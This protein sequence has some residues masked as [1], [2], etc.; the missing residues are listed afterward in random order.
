MVPVLLASTD[1]NAAYGLE[2]VGLALVVVLFW[3]K[4]R[5]LLSRAMSA[6]AER[7][8]ASLE[9][10]KEAQLEAEKIVE[11][12]RTALDSA[13]QEAEALVDQSRHGAERLLEEG[14]RR[15]E[16]EYARVVARAETE[17]ALERARIEG[18]IGAELSDL[19]L[20][21]A[22]EIVEAELDAEAQHRLFSEVIE[23]AEAEAG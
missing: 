11:R 3:T 7:I 18:E 2:W 12:A 22:S 13:R 1:W 9:S 5:P 23:A 19:V 15:A 10:G 16:E 21:F 6:Q 14:R 8:R 17:V 4:I 20:R